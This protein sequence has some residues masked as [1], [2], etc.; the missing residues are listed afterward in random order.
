MMASEI[1]ERPVQTAY[2]A[3]TRVMHLDVTHLL[4]LRRE[5]LFP[6]QPPRVN[7]TFQFLSADDVRRFAQ[8]PVN[9]LDCELAERILRPTDYCIGATVNGELA[10]YSWYALGSIEA[11]FNRGASVSTGTSISFPSDMAFMYKGFVAP[12]YRGCGLYANLQRLA[13]LEFSKSGVNAI[14][15]TT[16]WSHESALSSLY[17]LGF[18]RLGIIWRAGFGDHVAS[19]Y[20][21]LPEQKAIKIGPRADLSRRLPLLS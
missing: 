3:L 16:D 13:L 6:I 1:V 7:A 10:A 14:L 11:E 12:R 19:F 18:Q 17:N 8:Q 15:T 2:R 4:M 20:P 21:R 9:E 5:T